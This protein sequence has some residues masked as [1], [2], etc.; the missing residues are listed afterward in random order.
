MNNNEK[1]FLNYVA[2]NVST[3]ENKI[4]EMGIWGSFETVNKVFSLWNK[5]VL[6]YKKQH[7]SLQNIE[8]QLNEKYVK[9][10]YKK[11]GANY[12][13]ALFKYGASFYVSD[14]DGVTHFQG[15]IN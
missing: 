7:D 10:P 9:T 5:N 13:I 1:T 2:T 11:Y 15:I 6:P 8:N 14:L 12:I 3:D 4:E